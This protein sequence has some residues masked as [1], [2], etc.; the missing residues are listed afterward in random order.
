MK[1][2]NVQDDFEK[3]LNNL[4]GLFNKFVSSGNY[5]L[6]DGVA[7]FEK[8]WAA[9]T[10]IKFA[11]GVGNG[12][13]ALEIC[14]R[15][16]G[17]KSGD[18]VITTSMTAFATILAIIRVGAKPVLA[19][20]VSSNALLDLD[21]VRRCISSKTKAIIIVHLYGQVKNMEEWK[22]LCK[23]HNLY[24]VEDC[25][26]AHGAT[27][28]GISAGSFGVMSAFS[29]YPTKN[30]GALGDA[31]AVCTNDDKLF[32]RAKSIRNYGQSE[33]YNHEIVGLNSRLDDLQG[34]ILT[35][36]LPKLESN[37]LQRKKNAKFYFENIQNP[38]VAF[39]DEPVK[40]EGHVFH[41]FVVTVERRNEFRDFL[42]KHKIPTLIHY[43]KAIHQQ[44]AINSYKKD[45][46]GLGN[47]EKHSKTCVSI[48][49]HPGLLE[50]ELSLI[51]KKINEFR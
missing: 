34:Y 18:E 13:D 3:H 23:K 33:Q 50:T 49:C 51:A 28:N 35:E 42:A 21:S 27:E 29:F 20:I 1:F 46:E 24:L 26:Q 30:L 6:G 7:G 41:Q 2:V 36:M 25:A 44:K 37:N 15:S 17:V 39:L 40:R 22:K 31:G 4:T 5:I 47:A 11:L 38:L 12:M 19:D 8:N 48:P 14:L 32:L 16:L 43:P 45:P 10:G 9:Y